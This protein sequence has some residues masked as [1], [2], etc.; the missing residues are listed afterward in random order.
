MDSLITIDE[1]TKNIE[2]SV[3]SIQIDLEQA[4]T[5]SKEEIQTL[6]LDLEE[7]LKNAPQVEI[8][9]KHYFSKGVYGREITFPKGIL[10][11]GKI[12]KFPAMN[13]LSKGE[14]TVISIDGPM[15]IKAPYTFV[16]SPGAKRV[17]YA[18]E[19]SVWTNFHGTTETNIELIE[20][21]FIAKDMEEFQLFIEENKLKE[22]E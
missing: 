22:L 3:V 18:H 21:E 2:P 15:R 7:Q 16:S 13:V 6:I 19:D 8:P 17:I 11:V 12:H 1:E 20:N 4:L 5:Y 14:V 10:I 9:Q